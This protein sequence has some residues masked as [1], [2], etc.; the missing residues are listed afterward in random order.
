[1]ADRA[2][3]EL[4]VDRWVAHVS[5][6]VDRGK[7]G[8]KLHALRRRRHTLGVG[9]SALTTHDSTRYNP[10]HR[11]TTGPLRRTAA[12]PQAPVNY[13]GI[14]G[15]F[16]SYRFAWVSVTHEASVKT[17]TAV[18]VPAQPTPR[19]GYVSRR[20]SPLPTANRRRRRKI[21]FEQEPMS[22]AKAPFVPVGTATTVGPGGSRS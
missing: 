5:D 12:P 19:A 7:P 9:I 13:D 2:V 3:A 18:S 20:S 6:P 14:D 17:A 15:T 4:V 8:S 10:D 22:S 16:R 21:W 1:M 11:D